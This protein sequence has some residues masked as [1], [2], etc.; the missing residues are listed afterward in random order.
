MESTSSGIV[1]PLTKCT[2]VKCTLLQMGE[3]VKN[4]TVYDLH[5]RTLET[6]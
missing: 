4:H 6:T 3:H 5:A 1:N 2:G